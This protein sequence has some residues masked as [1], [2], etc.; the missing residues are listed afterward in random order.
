MIV[1]LHMQTVATTRD[2]TRI[3]NIVE[4]GNWI[5]TSAVSNN[6][7]NWKLEFNLHGFK[8]WGQPQAIR[9]ATVGLYLDEFFQNGSH[10][11]MISLERVHLIEDDNRGRVAVLNGVWI[12]INI[13]CYIVRTYR[14]SPILIPLVLLFAFM[15]IRYK[16]KSLPGLGKHSCATVENAEGKPNGL[17]RESP[18]IIYVGLINE[19]DY[20]NKKVLSILTI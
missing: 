16:P 7:G 15:K 14:F 2:H 13:C 18:V 4:A 1:C 12:Q 19:K 5:T 3:R 6:V 11:S 17:Q 8:M 20:R 10:D 9:K